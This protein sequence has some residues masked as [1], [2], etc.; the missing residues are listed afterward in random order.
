M[1]Q[2][3]AQAAPQLAISAVSVGKSADA[4]AADVRREA[5]QITAPKHWWQRALGPVYAVGRLAAAFL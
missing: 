1:A 2:A 3:G 5:D 4:I